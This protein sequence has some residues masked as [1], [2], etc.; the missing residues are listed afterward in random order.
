[1]LPD[2]QKDRLFDHLPRAA[3]AQEFSA[4]RLMYGNYLKDYNLGTSI[5]ATNNNITFNG[6]VDFMGGNNSY[7]TS[8]EPPISGVTNEFNTGG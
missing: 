8:L 5:S 4:G 3:R 1:M 2:L 6:A 7:Y